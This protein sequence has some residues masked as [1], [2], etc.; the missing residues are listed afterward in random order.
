[1]GVSYGVSIDHQKAPAPKFFLEVEFDGGE[2]KKTFRV[3]SIISVIHHLES[4]PS[5]PS[6][7]ERRDAIKAE[8]MS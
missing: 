2:K 8:G 1:M 5:F 6:L 7:M 4:H 3:S